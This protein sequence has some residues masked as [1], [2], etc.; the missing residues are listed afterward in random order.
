MLKRCRLVRTPLWTDYPE[1]M[2]QF[3]YTMENTIPPE[4]VASA[5]ID[6]ITNGKYEGGTC[7]LLLVQRMQFSSFHSVL[8]KA[9]LTYEL[10]SV[11]QAVIDANYAPILAMMKKERRAKL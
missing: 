6:L 2:K 8:P 10:C 3:G 9:M 4:A 5:M 11:P 7:L 1:K